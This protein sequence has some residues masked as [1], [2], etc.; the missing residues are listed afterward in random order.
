MLACVIGSPRRCGCRHC[1]RRR[2]CPALQGRVL[3]P[4]P[5]PCH[6]WMPA[7]SS[8]LDEGPASGLPGRPAAESPPGSLIWRSRGHTQAIGGREATHKLFRGP[9]SS[10]VFSGGL[11]GQSS[12]TQQGALP[13]ASQLFQSRELRAG[14]PP[15]VM[16]PQTT[17]AMLLPSTLRRPVPCGAANTA[18]KHSS[19]QTCMLL[20]YRSHFK[21]SAKMAG[22]AGWHDGPAAVVASCALPTSGS[23]RAGI[24][25]GA[26]QA[27]QAQTAPSA[28][29]D[30]APQLWLDAH[31]AQPPQRQP[32]VVCL[33][34]R[35]AHCLQLGRAPLHNL[36]K[37][38]AQLACPPRRLHPLPPCAA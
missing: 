24:D 8:V 11:R 12:L 33:E 30:C 14:R 28:G 36:H 25:A 10:R 6:P 1:R 22:H 20:R 4:S 16:R 9:S 18:W 34:P 35:L 23:A 29:L 13:T 37:P 32:H 21:W 15:A 31:G 19:M 7:R 2:H 3:P 17:P 5:C 27:S 38:A 26:Q